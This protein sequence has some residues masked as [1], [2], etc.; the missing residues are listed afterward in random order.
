MKTA[1]FN[2]LVLQVIVWALVFSS[3]QSDSPQKVKHASLTDTWEVVKIANNEDPQF[4]LH[5]PTFNKL[6][7]NNDGSYIR[8]KNDETLEEG[9]W[10]INNAKTRLTLRNN[11]KVRKYEIVK[12]PNANSETFIIKEYINTP[13]KKRDIKYELTRM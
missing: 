5:Y 8:V 11:D 6:T 12:M 2:F 4:V 1:I 10:D 3:D 7:L 13:Y 9:H